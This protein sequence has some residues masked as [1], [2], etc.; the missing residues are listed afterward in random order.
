MKDLGTLKDK[1]YQ[2]FEDE[3]YK[4]DCRNVWG[5]EIEENIATIVFKNGVGYWCKLHSR[6][7]KKNSWRLLK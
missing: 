3:F 4:L 7:V 6:G 2:S 1:V 5:V